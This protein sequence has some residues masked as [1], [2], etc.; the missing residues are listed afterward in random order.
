[1]PFGG[2]ID[3]KNCFRGVPFPLNFQRA[4]YM[5]IEKV[6]KLLIGER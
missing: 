1:M 5:Q 2:P 6:E 3:E 4:F